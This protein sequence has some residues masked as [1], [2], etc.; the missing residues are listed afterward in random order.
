MTIM[1]FSFIIYLYF[2]VIIW[3][4]LFI[5]FCIVTLLLFDFFLHLSTFPP[6]AMKKNIFS[7]AVPSVVLH[8]S[9]VFDEFFLMLIL[10]TVIYHILLS[11]CV[12]IL[13]FK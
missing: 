12:I 11:W 1:I 3:F 2:Y 5:Y 10:I 4:L 6:N 9:L 13:P 8:L 7:T